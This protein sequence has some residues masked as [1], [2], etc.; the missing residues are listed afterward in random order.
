[1][2]KV[3]DQ[4]SFIFMDSVRSDLVSYVEEKERR[5]M[6]SFFHS[7]SI[8]SES[9]QSKFLRIVVRHRLTRMFYKRAYII[10]YLAGSC[11][12]SN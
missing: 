11:D 9:G 5:H 3:C 6:V 12:P 4:T 10:P 2:G 7:A 1:M 8:P